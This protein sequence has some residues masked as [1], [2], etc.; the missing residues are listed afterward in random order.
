MYKNY[1]FPIDDA[2]KGVFTAQQIKWL[3]RILRINNEIPVAALTE[4]QWGIIYETMVK[5]VPKF[6]WPKIKK[7]KLNHF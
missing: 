6:R 5:Y 2:L 7:G 4:Q 1:Q 3:K